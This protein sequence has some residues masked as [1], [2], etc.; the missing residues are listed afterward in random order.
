M[1][2][3]RKVQCLRSHHER[4]LSSPLPRIK[5][6]GADVVS[7]GVPF[8]QWLPSSRVPWEIGGKEAPLPIPHSRLKRLGGG[9]QWGNLAG[10]SVHNEK[11]HS[12]YT[13]WTHPCVR[14]CL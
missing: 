13:R 11:K 8:W 7:Y 5:L 1:S 6:P 9:P 2:F 4:L 14:L 12:Q 10:A 3:T